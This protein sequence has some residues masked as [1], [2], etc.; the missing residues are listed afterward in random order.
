VQADTAKKVKKKKF[1]ID[2]VN[3]KLLHM[4]P[5]MQNVKIYLHA[6]KLV[7][8]SMRKAVALSRYPACGKTARA[9]D[10]S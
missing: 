5:K 3:Q 8:F 2:T 7:S 1:L 10:M 9:Y 4:M 6:G